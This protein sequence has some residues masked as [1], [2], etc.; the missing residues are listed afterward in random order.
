MKVAAK[1]KKTAEPPITL[2]PIEIQW[3]SKAD[4]FSFRGIPICCNIVKL[5]MVEI[6]SKEKPT[7]TIIIPIFC[8]LGNRGV[9]FDDIIDD[10]R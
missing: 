3:N 7:P 10:D 5:A 8:K 6:I 9:E 4:V 2:Y 1:T